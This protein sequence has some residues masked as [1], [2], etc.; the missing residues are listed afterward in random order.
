MPIY[1]YI[2]IQYYD[3]LTLLTYY[4]ILFIESYIYCIIYIW[5]RSNG[6]GMHVVNKY[7]NEKNHREG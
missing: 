3:L 1:M 5:A 2:E 6:T 4:T 7:K